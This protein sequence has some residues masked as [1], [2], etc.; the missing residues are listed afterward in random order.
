MKVLLEATEASI[1]NID[2]VRA[3]VKDM[4][5]QNAALRAHK[6]KKWKGKDGLW[7][8]HVYDAR[9]KEKRRLIKRKTEKELNK[10]IIEEFVKTH[11]VL[12]EHTLETVYP[13]WLGYFKLHTNKSCTVKRYTT[14]WTRYYQDDPIIKKPLRQLSKIDLDEWVHKMIKVHKMTKTQYYTMS[15][16]LR[17]CMIYA[18]EKGYIDKNEFSNIKIETKM[19]LKQQKK[20]DET[21]VYLESEQPF[22]IEEAWND[23]NKNPDNTTPLAVILLFYLGTRPGEVVAIR[24]EDVEEDYIHIQRMETGDFVEVEPGKYKRASRSVVEHTKTDAGDRLVPLIGKAVK[25]VA[26]IKDVN[27]RLG[28]SGG[29]LFM[30]KGE[31]VKE[32]AV[33]WRLQKYCNHLNIPYRS[34]HKIRKTVISSMI[35]ANVNI[36]TIRKIVGHEDEKTTYNNYC[37]DRKSNDEIRKQ[38]E[39]ALGEY[40][41]FNNSI[42]QFRSDTEVTISNQSQAV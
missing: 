11:S 22:I 39:I 30:Y 25:I 34:P 36:N 3:K 2:D 9:K 19:F 1:I 38:L 35:D 14:E 15:Y 13:E 42:I 29:Y 10:A 18:E 31:R 8:T 26:L 41:R 5:E 28:C 23:Y 20:A 21:Q 33:S 16:I 12:K 7:Y 40:K 37:F 6:Y 27:K 32:T 24:E 17:H 4:K